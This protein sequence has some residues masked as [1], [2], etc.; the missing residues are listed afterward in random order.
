MH[1]YIHH[2]HTNIHT[3]M[4][5]AVFCLIKSHTYI[6]TYIHTNLHTHKPTYT[7][8]CRLAGVLPLS[9]ATIKCTHHTQIHTYT[10]THV[11][12]GW[13]WVRQ[14]SA[15]SHI[16]TQIHTCIHTHMCSL[17]GALWGR[18]LSTKLARPSHS[19]L[20]HKISR[21][22]ARQENCYQDVSLSMS[23][24]PSRMLCRVCMLQIMGSARPRAA[25]R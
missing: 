17:A 24:R 22:C 2:T 5:V 25:A 8:M 20:Q 16:H 21:I 12:P 23:S 1:T 10:H 6:H 18:Q 13:R 15:H 3:H 7:H 4:C 14:L 9:E 11:Q 19:M